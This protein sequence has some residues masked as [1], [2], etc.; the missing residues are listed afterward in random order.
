MLNLNPYNI[1]PGTI[2]HGT[3]RTP[4]LLPSFIAEGE[5]ALEA[6]RLRAPDGMQRFKRLILAR[7]AEGRGGTRYDDKWGG[8]EPEAYEL[9]RAVRDAHAALASDPEGESEDAHAA[10]ASLF[11][12]LESIAPD[13]TYFGSIEGDGADFGFWPLESEQD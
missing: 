5:R 4:D 1:L 8:V 9:A 10:L 3:L 7:W 6:F 13:G 12:A 11:D 2:S